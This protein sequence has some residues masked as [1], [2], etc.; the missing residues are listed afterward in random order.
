MEKGYSLGEHNTSSN[1][2]KTTILIC[3]DAVCVYDYRGKG[4]T[5]AA[6]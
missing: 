5:E 3:T 2:I 6:R 4:K 1:F